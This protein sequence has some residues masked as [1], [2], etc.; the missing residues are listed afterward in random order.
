[1]SSIPDPI[2]ALKTLADE[3]G[4]RIDGTEKIHHDYLGVLERQNRPIG[5]NEISNKIDHDDKNIIA[6]EVEPLLEKL[7]YISK[8]TKGRE[9]TTEGREYIR[10]CRRHSTGS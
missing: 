3:R 10:D 2:A 8:T 1:M 5:I 4:L 6:E 7:G 9:I